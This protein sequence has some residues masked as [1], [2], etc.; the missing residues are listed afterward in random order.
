MFSF[1]LLTSHDSFAVFSVPSEARS[2]A[3]I[4]RFALFVLFAV[5]LF[6]ITAKHA[7]DAKKDNETQSLK[8]KR[9]SES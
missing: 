8:A 7:K 2:V 5:K 1:S 3:V 4:V 6:F 9:V